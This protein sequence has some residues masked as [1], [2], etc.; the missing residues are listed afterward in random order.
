MKKPKA[1]K[2][3]LQWC[4]ALSQPVT[5]VEEVPEGWYTIKQLAKA[6]GRSEC[7]TSEQ[8]RRMVEMGKAE[9]RNFTIRLA[10]RVRP[11][12]HYKLK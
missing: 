9:K 4:E 8:V 1:D 2:Q 11:V 3:L 7:N 10:E 6:R 5:P 12:P